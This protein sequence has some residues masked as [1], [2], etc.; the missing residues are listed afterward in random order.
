M[1]FIIYKK[2]VVFCLN[3]LSEY[4]GMN[5]AVPTLPCEPRQLTF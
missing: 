3:L 1:S 2:L 5:T 4:L